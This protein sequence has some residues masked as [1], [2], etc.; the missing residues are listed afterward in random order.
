[1]PGKLRWTIALLLIILL[2]VLPSMSE[3][4][5]TLD[6]L[7]VRLAS[8]EERD[9]AVILNQ[10]ADAHQETASGKAI[11]YAESALKI[12]RKY[13]D[14]KNEAY[15][16]RNLCLN[17][18]YNDVYHQALSNG[19]AALDIYEDLGDSTEI[20]YMLSTLGWVYYDIENTDLA[21]EYHQ[22]VLKIYQ[23]LGDKENVAFSY[24]S[25]GL[26]HSLKK[27]Y[28]KAL[29]FYQRSLRLAEETGDAIRA[30][31]A[32]SNLGMTYTALGS[33][34]L[35]LEHLQKALELREKDSAVLSKAEIWNQMGQAFTRKRNFAEAEE[36]FARAKAF[37]EQ[38]TSNASKEKLMD[39]LEFSAQLYAAKGDFKKAYEAS[40]E[41]SLIRNSILSEEKTS[42]L[43][44][45]RLIYETEKRENEIA[46]LENQKKIDRLIRNGSIAGFFLFIV[47]GYLTYSKLKSKN[48]QVRLEK[49]RL[50]DKL[51]FK[52]NELT[53]FGLHIA[54]R[55]EILSEFVSSLKSIQSNASGETESKL[56]NL[57]Q[58]IEQ[59]RVSNEELEAFHLNVEKEHKN[60]F[61]NLL[62]QFP[63]LTE[64]E[65]RLSAQLRLN[66]SNKDIAAIN[67][68]SVKS[69]E[70][71]RY[72]L[73]K[74][75]GLDHKDSLTDFLKSF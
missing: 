27:E 15:A 73:R 50:K 51:D 31:T 56:R 41:Y 48:R 23:E 37:I 21:L 29:D 22:R 62:K 65:K 40:R 45:M 46:L 18:L 8:V 4:Q 10:L 13:K 49:E 69:V 55:N 70:M 66:L 6:S 28:G 43:A 17:Y 60:F 9:K 35:A 42:K 16:L 1:M 58:R 52:N 26:V 25:L 64:H 54:Q 3:A 12:S 71:A 2:S 47:I 61:Y 63:D 44:E 59:S 39:N 5:V 33:Y 68:I 57:T 38:S 32:N 11:Q 19:L 14:R 30:S 53:T 72:R 75:F 7:E 34:D 20:A 74:R 36:A 24:N 67:N